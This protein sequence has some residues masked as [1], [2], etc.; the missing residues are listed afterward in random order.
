MKKLANKVAVITGGNSGIGLATANLFAEEGAKVAITGRNSASLDAAVKAIGHGAMGTVADVASLHDIE[1]GYKKIS[2]SFGKFDVLIVNAG[3]YF[4]AA[5]ADF[6]EELFDKLSDI[7]FKGA[8]F[9]VQKALPYLNEGASV[10][11]TSTALN[12]KGLA[13]ASVYSATKAAIRSLARS[14]SAELL[15]KNIRVNVLSPGAIVTPIFER[16][17]GSKEELDGALEY[18]SN[19]APAKRMGRPEEIAAGFLYLASDDSTYVL[20]SELV[21]DGGVKGI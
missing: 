12:E 1:A 3:I 16:A 11:L 7:N 19:Y 9:S 17:S 14:F 21:I 5:L 20:G 2:D 13:A 6:T 18:F 15:G 4:G 10:V 8:F